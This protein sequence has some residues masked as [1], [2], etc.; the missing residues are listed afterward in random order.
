M[1]AIKKSVAKKVEPKTE[2]QKETITPVNVAS[3]NPS[4]VT[5]K[6][7]SDKQQVVPQLP[8]AIT[9]TRVIPEEWKSLSQEQIKQLEILAPLKIFSLDQGCYLVKLQL[10]GLSYHYDGTIRVEKQGTNTVASGDLYY[11]KPLSIWPTLPVTTVGTSAV[12]TSIIPVPGI[13]SIFSEPSPANGI[14]VFSRANYRYYLKITSILEWISF[15]NTFTMG[16]EMW[17]FNGVSASPM[18]TNEGLFKA[19][20]TFGTAPSSYPSGA[21]Y[22]T[23]TVKN[24]GGVVVG[25]ISMGWVSKY[26]RKATVEIDR[27]S[28]SEPPM[29]SGAGHTWQSVFDQVGWELNVVQSNNNVT[30]VSGASWSDGEMH[31]AMV[32]WRD[33]ANLD[34]EWRYHI[35]AVRNIDST[36]RGIMYDNGATDSNNVPREG[37]GISSHWVIPNTS[38]WGKVKNMR[39]GT[40]KAPYF[41][42]ALH[43]IG[44]AMGLYH[45][46]VDM[47]IMNTTDVISANAVPPVQF[48]DNVKWAHASDDQKRLRHMPDIFV[49]PGGVAFGTAYSVHPLS[50][51]DE[52][53]DAEGLE[54]QVTPV[55]DVLPIGAPVRLEIVL[56]NASSIALPAPESLNMKYGCVK[57]NVIDP[58]GISRSFSTLIMCVDEVGLTY[59][60]PGQSIGNALTLLRGGEGALFP[61]PGA[62]T[63]EVTVEW[64]LGESHVGKTAQTNVYVTA[65]KS[66]EHARAAMKVLT[67]PDTLL[68]IAL[69]GDHLY[70]G[71]EAIQTA[72]KDDVLRPYYEY[73]EAKR[74]AQPFNNRKADIKGASVLINDETV[75]NSAEIKKAAKL[76]VAAGTGD[77]NSHKKIVSVLKEKADNSIQ[78]ESTQDAVANLQ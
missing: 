56:A 21:D 18:W 59:L 30:E 57:G 47:G 13:T 52:Q 68:S 12:G 2:S 26:L 6:T 3:K 8:S 78:Q 54:L 62:Y 77:S 31:N 75:M 29:D 16:F 17:K 42:T 10:T 48:P 22:L 25:N 53:E 49:R 46:T 27:V 5:Q 1:T 72:L 20:L 45:N 44:H 14:P 51:D 66:D 40:A 9:T 70:E 34:K 15:S 61:V 58:S 36:P 35:L 69:T 55:N 24:A 4:T 65:A 71:N 32:A 63:V 41:R 64:E 37:I 76:L 74:L 38:A 28:V 39:F 43:E 33:S 73:I 67:T 11:H 19:D 60:Q 7:G 23:G 50:P